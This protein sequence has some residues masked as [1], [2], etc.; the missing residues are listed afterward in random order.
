MK[1]KELFEYVDEIME[2]VFSD[3]VKLRWLNQIEAEL[4]VDVLLL[5]PK[6]IVQYTIDELDAELLAPPPYDELY[7]EYLQYRVC[8]AQQEPERANNLAATFNRA[9][10]EY[11]R[12]VAETANPGDG[13][14]ERMQ[15]YL[16]AYQIAVKHGETRTETEWVNSL[17]GPKGEDG[18]GLNIRG[19]VSSDAELPD[20][21]DLEP[22]A[23]YFVGTGDAP[24]LWIWN[25]ETW[26][27]KKSIR[28]G[29]GR[30]GDPG[31]NG[32]SVTADVSEIGGGFRVSMKDADGV[33][34]FDLFHG[35]QAEYDEEAGELI[36]TPGG[37]QEGGQGIGVPGVGIDTVEQTTTSTEDGGINIITVTKTDGTQ[38]TFQVRNGSRG[39][40]GVGIQ[41]VTYDADTG[42]WVFTKTDSSTSTVELPT[43]ADPENYY[44]KTKIDTMFGSYVSDIAEIVGGDA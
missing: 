5:A 43:V 19:Q 44:D 9:Y 15:Y 26:F 37:S 32:V 24:E 16:T 20:T 34:V 2:N 17:R 36:V 3:T 18:S 35:I 7:T 1:V 6:G 4:Q 41:S 8:L 28:G 25:G 38:H 29:D 13:R 42:T 31:K 11:V 14:A 30:P 40:D 33:H 22:G 21:N 10:N 12:H 39:T 23:G 27:Y